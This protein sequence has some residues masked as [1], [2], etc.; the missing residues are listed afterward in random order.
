MEDFF[1]F[2]L[3]SDTW[4][5]AH[6]ALVEAIAEANHGFAPAYGDDPMTQRAKEAFYALFGRDIEVFFVLNGTGA[7]VAALS[8]LAGRGSGVVCHTGAHINTHETGAPEK[9]LGVKLLTVHAQGGKLLP[10]DVEAWAAR[11][12]YSHCVSPD[13]VSLSQTTEYGTV[14]TPEELRALCDAAHNNRMLV[15]MDG[16]R[17]GNAVA[18]LGCTPAAISRDAGVDVLCFGGTKNGFAFGEAIVFFNT[19][20]ARRFAFLQK[21]HLQLASKTRFVSAQ[22][23]AALE[24]GLW[25]DMAADANRMAARLQAALQSLPG[26]QWLYPVESNQLFLQVPDAWLPKLEQWAHC[27]RDE[28]GLLRWVT[29]WNTTQEQVDAFAEQVKTLA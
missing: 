8:A 11:Q 6:P 29:A 22:F 23:A 1:T 4:S 21:Q 17:F 25:L 27:G 16:A 15:H 10:R 7:N 24:G 18:A 28:E 20:L 26:I 9:L 2:S 14:Y 13:V 19:E 5:P 3:T 12:D